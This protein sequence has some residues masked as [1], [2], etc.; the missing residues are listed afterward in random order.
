MV[1][2]AVAVIALT[3]WCGATL[4][5]LRRGKPSKC[6]RCTSDRIRPSWP[7]AVEKALPRVVCPYRCE[8]CANRFFARRT[9]WVR[10]ASI[11]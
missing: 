7:Q 11:Q 10:D 1:L 8:A 9:A 3:V 6:P 5:A 2:L 4:L